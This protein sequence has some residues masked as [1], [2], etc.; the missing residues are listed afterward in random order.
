M[1]HKE[2]NESKRKYAWYREKPCFGRKEL[3]IHA[4]REKKKKLAHGNK[5]EQHRLKEN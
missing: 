3:G 4:A 1:W 5:K 2:I